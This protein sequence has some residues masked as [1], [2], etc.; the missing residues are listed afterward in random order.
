MCALNVDQPGRRQ[1]GLTLIVVLIAIASISLAAVTLVR[2][3][4]TGTLVLGN[5]GF[6]RA[7]TAVTDNGLETATAW[8]IDRLAS[9]PT[10]LYDSRCAEGCSAQDSTTAYYATSLDGLDISGNS[11]ATDRVLIDWEDDGCAYAVAGS[12]ANCLAASPAVSANGYSSRYVLM[13]VCKTVG[14]PNVSGNNCARPTSM[15][16]ASRQIN[17]GGLDYG[18]HSVLTSTGGAGLSALMFRIVVR[19]RGPRNTVSYTETYLSVA[20]S[21]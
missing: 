4:D 7:T 9:A 21:S 19:A 20:E 14:D 3:V 8:L 2:S 11:K 1:D 18:R 17:K 5:L 16:A 13:R 6:K 15:A 12:F 10:E